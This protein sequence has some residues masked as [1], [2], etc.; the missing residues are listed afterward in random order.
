ML[1]VVMSKLADEE[2][3]IV[4]KELKG[5][6]LATILAH[7]VCKALDM[8]KNSVYFYFDNTIMKDQN[9]AC[10]E[11]GI[12]GLTKGVE[13]FIAKTANEVPD[14]HLKFVPS[15]YNSAEYLTRARTT[16]KLFATNSIWF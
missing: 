2:M 15:E 13:N 8:D 16:E 3:T 6:K 14:G 9:E 7:R 11:K 10:R 5:V 1:I 12:N 4:V